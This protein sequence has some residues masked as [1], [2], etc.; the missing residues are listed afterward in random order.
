MTFPL[1]YFYVLENRFF[2]SRHGAKKIQRSSIT[3][4]L[5]FGQLNCDCKPT[6]LFEF[7]SRNLYSR[8]ATPNNPPIPFNEVR[9]TSCF[10]MATLVGLVIWHGT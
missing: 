10:R 2:F 5:F 7:D 9:D 4:F 1:S 8:C 6:P 3:V